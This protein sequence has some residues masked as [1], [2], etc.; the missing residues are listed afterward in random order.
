M[1]ASIGP[2]LRAPERRTPRDSR[3]IPLLARSGAPGTP[4]V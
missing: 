1:D 2:R 4:R 3:Q